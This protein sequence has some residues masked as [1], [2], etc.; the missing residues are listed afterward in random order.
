MWA[1]CTVDCV[2]LCNQVH[3]GSTIGLAPRGLPVS[4]ARNRR[5]TVILSVFTCIWWRAWFAIA[6][7]RCCHA[8]RTRTFTTASA[9]Y[10]NTSD[11]G[12]AQALTTQACLRVLMTAHACRT[13]CCI[14]LRN[15]EHPASTIHLADR[16]LP[17]P[18]AR[19]RRLAVILA[20]LTAVWRRTRITF[21]TPRCCGRP[22]PCAL[23]AAAAPCPNA[24]D[25]QRTQALITLACLRM[26]G[27]VRACFALGCG[28]LCHEIG[29]AA[30]VFLTCRRLP[31]PHTRDRQD[32]AVFACFACR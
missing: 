4:H 2:V 26:L 21:A 3:L 17:V 6:A 31:V 22:C 30:T 32:A 20:L 14:V 16:G 15:N 28:M 5:N 9:P 18:H 23:G 19:D 25:G 7:L 27:G 24:I 1:S 13:A 8:P 10:S 29:P 11:G 12:W